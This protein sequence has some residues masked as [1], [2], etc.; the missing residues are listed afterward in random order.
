MCIQ[1]GDTPLREDMAK[2]IVERP[3]R[4]GNWAHK[5]GRVTQD[6]DLMVHKEGMRAPHVR[7]WGGKELNE[8][9]APLRRFL[10]SRVGQPWDQVYSEI[11]ANL[12]V[13]SAVQQHVRDHVQDFVVT[14]VTQ[15][16]QGVL[17]GVSHGNPFKIG[18]GWWRRELYVDPHD[19]ILKRTPHTPKPPS[20]G[21]R[22][23][24]QFAET[25]RVID[26]HHELRKHKGIWYMC[27]V[28]HMTPGKWVPY[29]DTTTGSTRHT[30]VGGTHWD[31][32]WNK[33]L[34]WGEQETW[35]GTYVVTK[36][37]LNRKEMRAH[38][39]QND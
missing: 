30:L 13:T 1:Q 33:S 29:V 17:W 16:D 10:H 31:V 14:K 11:S 19:G 21:E 39:V 34:R 7:N 28:K 9:L 15:D 36:R 22:R 18:E 27:E 4:G 32:L 5:R 26:D 20:Y 2:V 23:E 25:H 37:Q 35:R 38:G 6:V 3:R 12:K 8:N 24:A